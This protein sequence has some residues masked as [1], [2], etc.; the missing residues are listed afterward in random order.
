MSLFNQGGGERDNSGY[1]ARQAEQHRQNLIREA[2]TGIDKQFEGFNDDYFKKY[3]TDYRGAYQP[4]VDQQYDKARRN[5]MLALSKSGNLTSS[6]G[7]NE[8]ASLEAAK[9]L[10][11]DTL[12]S[13]AIAA[14][15]TQRQNIE[16]GRGDLY[17]MASAAG[18]PSKASAQAATR[19]AAL[20][21]PVPISP[22]GDLFSS[23]TSLAANAAAAERAGYYGTGTGMFAPSG[24]RRQ[25]SY[26][27]Q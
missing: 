2:Q 6:Y 20:D 10:N 21:T 22:L 9:K 7:A 13:N 16:A 17:S 11:L 8:L 18:D 12:N 19:R 1:E 14:T 24:S 15:N 25:L 5:V 27:V 26:V 23:F 3:E 4:Q